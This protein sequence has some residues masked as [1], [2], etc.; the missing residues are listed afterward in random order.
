[1]S[2]RNDDQTP[3]ASLA[4][5]APTPV[6]TR[7]ISGNVVVRSYRKTWV[8][9]DS[10]ILLPDRVH[11]FVDIDMTAW[12]VAFLDAVDA[13]FVPKMATAI[14]A[15]DPDRAASLAKHK[16]Q[17][18]DI[19]APTLI[20]VLVVPGQEPAVEPARALFQQALLERFC[21]AYESGAG[22]RGPLLRYPPLPVISNVC[23]ATSSPISIA[24][25]LLWDCVATVTTS[26]AAQDELLLSVIINDLSASPVDLATEKAV[27]T[28]PLRPAATTLF[29]ALARTTVEHRQIAPH[30]SEVLAGGDAAVARAALERLD[31][32]IG[33][34]A[35]AWS[36]WFAR[37]EPTKV[38]KVGSVSA[39]GQVIWSYSVDFSQ[40]PVPQITRLP[41][42]SGVLPPWPAIAGCSTPPE[43]GQA[44]HRYQASA[45]FIAGTPLTFTW[46]ELPILSAQKA[47]VAASV[48]RNAGLVPPGSPD[49]TVVDSAFIY[50][51][52]AVHGSTSVS[53]FFD[54]PSQPFQVG[55]GAANLSDAMD[56]L[57]A[58]LLSGPTPG[59]LAA[60][61]VQIEM[62]ASYSISMGTEDAPIGSA[63]PI[64][65][66]RNTLALSPNV[67]DGSIPVAVFRRNVIDEL[68][69]WH[70]A[71][72]PDD[73][74][75]AIRFAINLSAA[76]AE[77][78]APPVFLGRVEAIVPIAQAD[79]WR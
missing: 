49:G 42:D 73:T 35:R 8:G 9:D 51:S 62:G 55:T 60:R 13:L 79:W 44:T 33:D 32:L 1:M 52:R 28:A 64:F 36:D 72:Q 40:L 3:A 24:E 37:A 26:Q 20:P 75:A 59:G 15:L 66:T 74:R 10:D 19:I 76:G 2:E 41:G 67:A 45:S 17:L 6:S 21:T 14:A 46:A 4:G 34:V 48:L 7:L 65:L 39:V 23:A 53:P 43:D 63:V 78:L 31:A 50:R 12:S 68:V 18:A 11:A 27:A 47:D 57:F 5:F 25:A 69:G 58:S 38:A 30:L 70:A 71:V 56:D 54:L 29:E 77:S 61:D 16:Q 22:D